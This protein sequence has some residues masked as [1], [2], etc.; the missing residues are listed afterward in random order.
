MRYEYSIHYNEVQFQWQ[1][2][3]TGHDPDHPHKMEGDV[4]LCP[5]FEEAIAL[6]RTFASRYDSERMDAVA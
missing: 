1:V 3:W 5:T 4:V 6:I 2:T